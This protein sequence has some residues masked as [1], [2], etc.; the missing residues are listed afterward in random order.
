MIGMGIHTDERGVTLIELMVAI[1][2]LGVVTS[3][4]FT[5]ILNTQRTE[6][7]T[8]QVQGAMDDARLSLENIRQ[9]I[10]AARMVYA[11]STPRTMYFWVDQNQDAIQDPAEKICYHVADIAGDPGRYTL[12]RWTADQGDCDPSSPTVP[13]TAHT[14]AATLRDTDPFTYTPTPT[15][16]Q[17][18]REVA[19]HM[20]FDVKTDTGPSA[21]AVDGTVRLRNVA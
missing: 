12:E 3:T 21:F 17:A 15:A 19:I 10:R 18:T 5:V 6:R 8:S 14:I 13:A 1:L 2:M 9:E 4:V 20:V 7:F 11:S 16:T